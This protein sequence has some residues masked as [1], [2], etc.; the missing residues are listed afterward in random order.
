M[1]SL[2]YILEDSVAF[3]LNCKGLTAGVIY[4][5]EDSFS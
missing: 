3:L 4:I 2:H 1:L 5:Y